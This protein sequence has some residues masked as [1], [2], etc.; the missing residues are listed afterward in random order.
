MFATVLRLLA[1]LPLL[2]VGAVAGVQFGSKSWPH[3]TGRVMAG[4][5][6]AQPSSLRERPEYIVTYSYDVEARNY[7]GRRISWAT[8]SP[9][10][11]VNGG[12]D[13]RQPQE[14]DKIEVYY[15]PWM[16]SLCVLIPGGS[17][18]LWIWGVV[19]LLVGVMLWMV[20]RGSNHPMY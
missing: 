10:V 7:T 6:E 15:A 3:V 14:E 20:A 11:P 16:P 13:T 2:I 8:S 12:I 19:A 9:M 18:S 5:W 1:I 17:P 4:N